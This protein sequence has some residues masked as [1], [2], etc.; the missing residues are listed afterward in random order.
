MTFQSR[1]GAAHLS[2]PAPYHPWP[3]R[4]A[5]RSGGF[6]WRPPAGTRTSWPADI[7]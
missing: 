2:W 3:A 6:P 1:R 5:P 7:P 4:A